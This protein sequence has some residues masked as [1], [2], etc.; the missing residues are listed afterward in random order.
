MTC[1]HSK[2]GN[3]MDRI[4]RL[5][6]FPRATG[7]GST[8]TKHLRWNLLGSADGRLDFDAVGARWIHV[9]QPWCTILYPA[10]L[11]SGP[12]LKLEAS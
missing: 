4:P 11:N 5:A 3:G 1:C 12:N 9:E 7:F 6:Q 2:H 8:R 10:L